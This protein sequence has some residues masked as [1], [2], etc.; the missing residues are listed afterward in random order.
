[1]PAL[2]LYLKALGVAEQTNDTAEFATILVKLGLLYATQNGHARQSAGILFQ[3]ASISKTLEDKN[4]IG[5]IIQ[6]WRTVFVRGDVQLAVNYFT[7]SLKDYGGQKIHLCFKH[8]GKAYQQKGDYP[9]ALQ[10]TDR[11][12]TF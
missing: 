1:M 10:F 7:E 4:I 6:Y 9:T 5:T 12:T 2:E 11:L 3:G 8:L